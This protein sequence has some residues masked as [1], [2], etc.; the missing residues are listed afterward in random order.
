MK[1]PVFNFVCDEPWDSMTGDERVRRCARCDRDVHALAAHARGEVVALLSGSERVCAQ[2]ATWDE[3]L[4]TAAR[5]VVAAAALAGG[6]A[7]AA[8]ADWTVGPAHSE[9]RLGESAAGRTLVVTTATDSRAAR[10][11]VSVVAEDGLVVAAVTTD[12]AGA[13]VLPDLAPGTYTFRVDAPKRTIAYVADL[14]A[15]RVDLVLL[16][17]ARPEI[18]G[19][20]LKL[21]Q[22]RVDDFTGGFA[23][24]V[25]RLR[26][27]RATCPASAAEA[28]ALADAVLEQADAVLAERDV[29]M[30]ADLQTFLEDAVD[31]LVAAGCEPAAVPAPGP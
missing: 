23:A 4:L 10:V 26:G 21:S 2:V 3:R 27:L 13:A 11:A 29:S 14:S 6:A 7:P 17:N 5:V 8:A 31:Q 30:Y 9:A 19:G 16:S 1:P 15:E 18:R 20:D 25:A 12:D 28:A 24:E 22:P